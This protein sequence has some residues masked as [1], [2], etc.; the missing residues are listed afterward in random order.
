MQAK[1]IIAKKSLNLASLAWKVRVL[2]SV[3]L[4]VNEA[5]FMLIKASQKD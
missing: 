1:L 2:G 4:P 5:D 3:K